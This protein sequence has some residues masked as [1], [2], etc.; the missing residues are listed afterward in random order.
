M[1]SEFN[2][3]KAELEAISKAN[4]TNGGSSAALT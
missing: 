4:V 1:R 2:K 3:I